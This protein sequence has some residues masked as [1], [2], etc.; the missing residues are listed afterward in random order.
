MEIFGVSTLLV[1]AA[2]S[3]SAADWHTNCFLP[4]IHRYLS[5]P[6]FPDL[7]ELS[8]VGHG[9]IKQVGARHATTWSAS[10]RVQVLARKPGDKQDAQLYFQDPS[11]DCLARM[12]LARPLS[13]RKSNSYKLE[14][15]VRDM[16]WQRS[17]FASIGIVEINACPK[18]KCVEEHNNFLLFL[19]PGQLDG[20]EINDYPWYAGEFDIPSRR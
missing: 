19:G 2:P 4:P 6:V 8:L 7:T 1:G 13:D 5:A 14:P 20:I 18:N 10:Q 17:L 3:L 16:C 9:V 15:Q 12:D 11:T